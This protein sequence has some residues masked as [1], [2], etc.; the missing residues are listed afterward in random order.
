MDVT[1]CNCDFVYGPTVLRLQLKSHPAKSGSGQ[2]FGVGYP[3][4]VSGRK[5][6]SVH[7]YSLQYRLCGFRLWLFSFVKRVRVGNHLLIVLSLRCLQSFLDVRNLAQTDSVTYCIQD[8]MYCICKCSQYC[9][10]S[11]VASVAH[12]VQVLHHS[13]C[14][15]FTTGHWSAPEPRHTPSI[16]QCYTGSYAV[17]QRTPD[18]YCC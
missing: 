11:E 4:S 14:N 3:N 15:V 16:S 7:P 10:I 9:I 8:I 1:C 13:T 12:T 18:M 6:I 2:I 5:S 17:I